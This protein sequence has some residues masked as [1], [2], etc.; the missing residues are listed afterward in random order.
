MPVQR[1]MSP[2]LASDTQQIYSELKS[3]MGFE[4]GSETDRMVLDGLRHEMPIRGAFIDAL[5]SEY[6]PLQSWP[7][8]QQSFPGTKFSSSKPSPEMLLRQMLDHNQF[9]GDKVEKFNIQSTRS[10]STV[11]DLTQSQDDL[12]LLKGRIAELESRR[13]EL[14]EMTDNL[15]STCSNGKVIQD[16]DRLFQT[17]FLSLVLS[18][19]ARLETS[20]TDL[21]LWLGCDTI[22]QN[23][24]KWGKLITLEEPEA[25]K[26]VED[27]QSFVNELSPLTLRRVLKQCKQLTKNR[28]VFTIT[29]HCQIQ[30]STRF[31]ESLEKH[32]HKPA[33]DVS[34]RSRALQQ[35]KES[36]SN[37]IDWLWE[38][39][40]PVANMCVVGQFQKPVLNR[41]KTSA[42]QRNSQNTTVTKYVLG[43]LQYLDERLG[44][45]TERTQTLVYHR[46]ALH[47]GQNYMPPANNNIALQTQTLPPA[48]K[49]QADRQRRAA[50]ESLKSQMELYGTIPVNDSTASASQTPAVLSGYTRNR[51]QKVDVLHQ[52]MQIT[53]ERATKAGIGNHE[54]GIELLWESITSEVSSDQDVHADV[55][56]EQLIRTL[57]DQAEQIQ[58]RFQELSCG[59]MTAPEYIAH[60]RSQVATRLTDNGANSVLGRREK[61]GLAAHTSFRGPDFDDFLRRWGE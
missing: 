21:D 33:I 61:T 44:R 16:F 31:Q 17:V 12:A 23:L 38:E 53:F 34:Q 56:L 1:A 10:H 49:K 42:R 43:V 54:H 60:A 7:T 24:Q 57:G 13:E 35:E 2:N 14:I 40:I 58:R 18:D 37:E 39:I 51:A 28:L 11:Q 26:S 50:L 46:Q 29:Q 52:D 47:H 25:S 5:A 55:E 4:E 41:Y 15:Q 3:N 48:G 30:L 6:G 8:A 59:D 20:S 27:V 32:Y 19:K 22:L 9:L 45:V 36:I